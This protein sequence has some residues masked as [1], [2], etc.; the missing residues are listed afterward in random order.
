[1][2]VDVTGGAGA[3]APPAR[4]RATPGRSCGRPGVQRPPPA[5]RRAGRGD[6]APDRGWPPTWPTTTWPTSASATPAP[7]GTSSTSRPASTS[8]SSPTSSSGQPV[9]DALLVG[10]VNTSVAAV[11][12]IVLA[13]VLGVV[14]GV[15]RL[16]NSWVSR[17]AATS[18][19]RPSATFRCC[20]SSSSYAAGLQTLPPIQDARSTRRR[21]RDLQ[22]GHRPSCRPWRVTTWVSTSR[23]WPSGVALAVAV[24]AWRTRRSAATGTPDHR[25]LWAGGTLLAVAVG[26]YFALGSP[27]TWSHPAVARAGGVVGGAV[28]DSPYFAI[29]LALGVYTA[30]TSPRSSG[31][32]SR[33]CPRA[34][35]RPPPPSGLA[36]L[37]RL[38]FVILPQAFRIAVPPTINQDLSLVKNTS[39]GIAVAYA[40]I[41]PPSRCT[42]HRLLPVA[43]AADRSLLLMAVLPDVLA[44]RSRSLLN[45]VNRRLSW[46]SDDRPPSGRRS[47]RTVGAAAA[48]VAGR[49]RPGRAVPPHTR[50]WARQ[51]P[52]QRR[53]F[54]DRAHPGVRPAAGVDGLYRLPRFVFVSRRLG[55]HPGATCGCS[56][57]AGSRRRGLATVG[58]ALPAG[59]GRRAAGGIGGGLGRRCRPAPRAGRLTRSSRWRWV[60]RYWPRCSRCRDP[61]QLA[62]WV[63]ALCTLGAV[64]VLV[65]ARQVGLRLPEVGTRLRRALVALV[66]VT[67][68]RRGQ[69]RAVVRGRRGP[70]ARSPGALSPHRSLGRRPIRWAVIG[71]IAWRC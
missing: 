56:W 12:G 3:P 46:S 44:R 69:R 47:P 39:L 11:V 61:G 24:A 54:N 17:K 55:D 15:L 36:E 4:P 43:G 38:R 49:R 9:K 67:T 71:L 45:I 52:V 42:A 37:Q 13:T 33:R 51:Q 31:A 63:P 62:A 53:Q 41:T 60:R 28:L 2:A 8:R 58:R 16:S 50:Q 40:E 27:I 25:Y 10:I 7:A 34:R 1:M 35:P 48:R 6:R 32:A 29:T 68:G 59:R 30:A 14:V 22:P 20:W 26:G 21:V 19:S 18:T 23:C 57:S 70:L 5:D 65:G 64:A 66:L